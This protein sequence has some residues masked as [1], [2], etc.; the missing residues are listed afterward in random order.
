M[1]KLNFFRIK[2]VCYHKHLYYIKYSN[3]LIPIWIKLHLWNTPSDYNCQISDGWTTYLDTYSNC[4]EKIKSFKSMT[5]I[6]IF[7][8][9]IPE[10][11]KKFEK[12][13]EEFFRE[14]VSYKSKEV[15]T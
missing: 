3:T 6:K 12:E 13:K 11:I 9:N 5:D 15:K 14:N 2:V 10:K 8:K 4:E 1:G 7:Y